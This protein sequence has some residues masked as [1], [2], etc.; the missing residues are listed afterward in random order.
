MKNRAILHF[1]TNEF[2]TYYVPIKRSLQYMWNTHI[3]IKNRERDRQMKSE[4]GGGGTIS[5]Y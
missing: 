1:M 4:G 3:F 2:A 5:V